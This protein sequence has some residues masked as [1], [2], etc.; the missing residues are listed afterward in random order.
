MEMLYAPLNKRNSEASRST[1]MSVTGEITWYRL[2]NYLQSLV[3][4]FS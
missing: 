4:L 1:F 3:Y 2:E